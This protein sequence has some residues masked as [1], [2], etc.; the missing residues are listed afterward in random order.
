MRRISAWLCTASCSRYKV[1][2]PLAWMQASYIMGANKAALPYLPH[3]ADI[4]ALNFNELAI[5]ANTISRRPASACSGFRGTA[6]VYAPFFE[7]FLFPFY[8]GG[9]VVPS[10]WRRPKRFGCDARDNPYLWIGVLTSA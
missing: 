9:V 1:A 5:W 8:T 10:A 6:S 3:G 7:V 4:N 2:L